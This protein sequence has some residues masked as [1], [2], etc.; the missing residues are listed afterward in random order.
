MGNSIS[1]EWE[2]I[3]S[4]REW[5]KY[6]TEPVI[7]FVARN[8]YKKDRRNTKLLDYGCG[9]GAHTWYLARE[10]FDT[11]AFD[12]S[13]SAVKKA[14]DYLTSEGLN[15]HFDV[16][17]ATNVAYPEKFFD[18]VIDSACIGHNKIEDITT[19]YSMIYKVLK[20]NGRLFTSFFST[21]TTGFGTGEQV[22]GNT[23]RGVTV[24][25][26]AGL[27]V[28]HFWEE[29]ELKGIIEEIGFRDIEIERYSHMDHGS[30]I[31]SFVLTATKY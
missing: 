23:Y 28:V 3:H 4:D 9:Q 21:K 7:R 17:D 2:Q 19:M 29:N 12:G 26:L 11:Y 15:A 25:P 20:E 27:G 10:G 1:S 6:P 31:D 5:G 14:R 24:G 8:F 13:P 16:M 30:F 18:G 22:L